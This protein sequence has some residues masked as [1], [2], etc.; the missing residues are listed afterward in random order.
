MTG[1]FFNNRH[2]REFWLFMEN[3]HRPLLPEL[4]RNDYEISGRHGTVS[5]GGE[6]YATRQIAVD[7]TFVEK[8]VTRLQTLAREI[9]AWLGRGTKGL[10]W[11]DDE[12]G[13]GYDAVVYEAVDTQQIIRT[14]RASVVFECQPLAKTIHFLQSIHGD[15]SSGHIMDVFSNG[16]MPT[17]VIIIITNTGAISTNNIRITR[18]A[19]NR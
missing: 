2:S 1:F 7:I 18:R 9:A 10:L 13:M 14:K 12:I 19:L 15:V 5:F 3:A 8:D 6:T 17:P 16:T 11:F 4:R